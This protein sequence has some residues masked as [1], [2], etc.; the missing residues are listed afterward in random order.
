MSE[1]EFTGKG[2]TIQD[3][4]NAA[5]TA[6]KKSVASQGSD[7]PVEVEL[8]SVKAEHNGQ[9]GYDE[10]QVVVKLIPLP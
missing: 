9:T 2:A 8:V 10:T 7:I 3:A 4:F 6:A 1:T 5:F